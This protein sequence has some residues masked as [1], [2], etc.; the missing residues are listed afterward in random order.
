[1]PV[2]IALVLVACLL[3]GCGSSGDDKASGPASPTPAPASTPRTAL[4][5]DLADLPLG[6]RET[7]VR[8]RLGPPEKVL[9]R[10]PFICLVYATDGGPDTWVRMCFKDGRMTGMGTIAGRENAMTLPPEKP[11]STEGLE[12]TKPS[13]KKSPVRTVTPEPDA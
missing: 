10:A 9:R 12:Q 2:R 1:M 4:Q 11:E 6:S 3:A 13:K 7:A 5:A 8:E